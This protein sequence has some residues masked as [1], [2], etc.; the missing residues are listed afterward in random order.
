MVPSG[1]GQSRAFGTL[2]NVLPLALGRGYTG[3]DI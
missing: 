3:V 2:E 1:K